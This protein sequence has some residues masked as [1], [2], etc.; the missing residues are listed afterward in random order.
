MTAGCRGPAAALSRGAALGE[1]PLP[2]ALLLS[3]VC[4]G[5][6][7]APSCLI[8]YQRAFD[9]FLERCKQLRNYRANVM[10]NINNCLTFQ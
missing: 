8:S 5:P 6:A 10:A 4:A 7:S 3:G 1:A 2:R 9:A